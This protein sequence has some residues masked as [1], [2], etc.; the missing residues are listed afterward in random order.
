MYP[1]SKKLQELHT[2]SKMVTELKLGTI[3]QFLYYQWLWRSR[4][5]QYTIIFIP[6]EINLLSPVQSGFCKKYSILTTLIDISDCIL[7][8]VEKGKGTWVLCLDLKKAFATVNHSL[9][10]KRL[11]CMGWGILVWSGLKTI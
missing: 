8:D 2:Y 1:K 3:N 7:K 5:E 10:L 11:S 9:L 4:K 6:P